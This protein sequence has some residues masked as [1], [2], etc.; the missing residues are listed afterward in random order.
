MKRL[1][2]TSSMSVVR[3]RGAKLAAVAA[4]LVALGAFAAFPAAAR[5]DARE[6]RLDA[7]AH[8]TSSVLPVNFRKNALFTCF[9]A[10]G[11]GTPVLSN[12]ATITA[13]STVV[14]AVVTVKARPGT[15]V[16][17]QL[18]QSGCLKLKFF[19]F[20]IPASGVGTISVNDLRITNDA[21]VWF[22][23]TAGDFQITPEVILLTRR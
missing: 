5:H 3:R 16:F 8:R 4:G 10:I 6:H 15:I 22:N 23:D 12:T 21:F 14:K 11:T 9:G 18:T 13:T 17:G 19:T 20:A 2:I 1:R 7:S